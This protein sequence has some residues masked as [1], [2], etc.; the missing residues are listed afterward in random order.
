MQADFAIVN[1]DNPYIIDPDNFM[2][3]SRN[4]PFAGR[5]VYGRI[6]YTVFKGKIH[7]WK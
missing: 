6:I 5:E 1:L 4:T 3:K 7:S 2:S